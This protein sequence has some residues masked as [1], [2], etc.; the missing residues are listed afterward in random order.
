MGEGGRR[1]KSGRQP[2]GSMGAFQVKCKK[3]L[4]GSNVREGKGR[5]TDSLARSVFSWAHYFQFQPPAK[6]V[7]KR[8]SNF[9]K[10]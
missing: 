6:Q 7:L 8:C 3:S 2:V 5:V 1:S 9:D 4:L 10:N